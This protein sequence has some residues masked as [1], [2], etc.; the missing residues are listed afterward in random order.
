MSDEA[1]RLI[2]SGDIPG[3]GFGQCTPL[4]K[5]MVAET[6]RL[7]GYAGFVIPS[8][9]PAPSGLHHRPPLKPGKSSSPM[10]KQLSGRDQDPVKFLLLRPDVRDDKWHDIVRGHNRQAERHPGRV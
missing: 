7:R 3:T 4:A 8:F 6:A 9:S 5:G 1:V 10:A 2:G